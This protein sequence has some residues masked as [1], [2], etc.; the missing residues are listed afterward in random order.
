MF[1]VRRIIDLFE[2]TNKI[3][4]PQNIMAEQMDHS[5]FAYSCTSSDYRPSNE[6]ASAVAPSC[7]RQHRPK[8]L[9]PYPPARVFKKLYRVVH[10]NFT[11]E[12]ELFCMLFERSL[13]IF[14]MLSLKQHI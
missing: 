10:L 5:I 3:N 8:S 1:R 11:A 13:S 2:G 7:C 6:T 4:S 14:S 9:S 12:I